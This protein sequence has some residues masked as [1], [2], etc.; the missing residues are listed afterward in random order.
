MGKLMAL[1]LLFTMAAAVLFQPVLM[2]HPGKS[3]RADR[4]RPRICVGPLSKRR[5]LI[6]SG[7]SRRSSML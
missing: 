5:V 2:G 1:A 4:V 7:R 3:M 6:V